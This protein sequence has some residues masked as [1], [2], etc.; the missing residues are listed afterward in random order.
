MSALEIE[1]KNSGIS[2]DFIDVI[3]ELALKS[4]AV[5][6]PYLQSLSHCEFD[7]MDLVLKDFIYQYGE[8]SSK[9]TAYIDAVMSNLNIQEHKDIL[10]ENLKEE[11]GVVLHDSKLPDSLISSIKGKPHKLLYREL[12]ERIGASKIDLPVASLAN[13]WSDNFLSLCSQKNTIGIGAIGIGT[14]RI[15]AEIYS[16]VLECFKKS[17]DLSREDLIFFELH[18]ECD[19]EHANNLDYIGRALAV[20]SK[21]ELEIEFGA[22]LALSLREMFWDNMYKRAKLIK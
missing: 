13:L 14:E 6:H 20:S 12:K 15:V 22:K 11:K 1:S 17:T 21:E 7:N 19:E 16:Q 4:R 9:F 2:K 5:K 8:Y 10:T 18:S 3:N